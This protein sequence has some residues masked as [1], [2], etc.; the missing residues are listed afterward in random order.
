MARDAAG[1]T[2]IIA[3]QGTPASH[4]TDPPVSGNLPL[5]GVS[6]CSLRAGHCTSPDRSRLTSLVPQAIPPCMGHGGPSVPLLL[7][8]PQLS[9][10]CAC[11][12]PRTRCPCR[13]SMWGALCPPSRM[14][15]SAPPAWAVPLREGGGHA[16]IFLPCHQPRWIR[17]WALVLLGQVH[18]P[19]LLAASQN[20]RLIHRPSQSRCRS[21]EP[22]G[23]QAWTV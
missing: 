22:Q 14:S 19:E 4:S 2:P 13:A 20:G 17:I 3:G 8:V 1:I 9:S 15:C 23:L 12:S 16:P 21:W 7:L 5:Q 11:S 18:L 10:P 6:E